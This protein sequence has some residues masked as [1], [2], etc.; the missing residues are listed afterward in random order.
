MQWQPIAIHGWSV[1]VY[2]VSHA[3][4]VTDEV[5]STRRAEV[6]S[7]MKK[8]VTLK[9]GRRYW[10]NSSKH[11]PIA[12]GVSADVRVVPRSVNACSE[13]TLQHFLRSRTSITV[14]LTTMADTRIAFKAGRAFRRENT[15]WVDPSATK[16]AVILQ[17]GEDGLLHFIW[18]DRSSDEIEEVRNLSH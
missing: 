7:T 13:T 2:L 16:G 12:R 6:V 10:P 17:N 9:A 4:R 18:K 5:R 8:T 1:I 11:C 3:R 15:N 14:R